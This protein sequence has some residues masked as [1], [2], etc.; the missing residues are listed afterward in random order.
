[1]KK[2]INSDGTLREWFCGQPGEAGGL[3]RSENYVDCAQWCTMGM[4]RNC[5]NPEWVLACSL[6]LDTCDELCMLP[7]E[8]GYGYGY[9]WTWNIY[10]YGYGYK[11]F[12]ASGKPWMYLIT[13][14]KTYTKKIYDNVI[15]KLGFKMVKSYN[16]KEFK[17]PATK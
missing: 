2:L 5:T 16:T 10:G 6:W 12:D 1:M 13:P 17:A 3:L 15:S 7:A 11:V 14:F 9:D 4:C 8:Y